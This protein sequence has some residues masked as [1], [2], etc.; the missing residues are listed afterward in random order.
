MRKQNARFVLG[1]KLAFFLLF[2]GTLDSRR[3][4]RNCRREEKW[5]I[6]VAMVNENRQAFWILRKLQDVGE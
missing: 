1:M 6:F 3:K 4:Y 2:F 5:L